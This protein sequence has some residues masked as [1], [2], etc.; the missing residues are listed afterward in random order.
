MYVYNSILKH[1]CYLHCCL[2]KQQ[3]SVVIITIPSASETAIIVPLASAEGEEMS[4]VFKTP[5]V[6]D[7]DISMCT[8][9]SACDYSVFL[10][11]SFKINLSNSYLSI[12]I[13]Y[14]EQLYK[15]CIYVVAVDALM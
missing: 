14:F 1:L 3:E 11:F 15:C 13:M 5:P 12:L 10:P 2:S 8:N 7:D 6:T 4:H 9:V